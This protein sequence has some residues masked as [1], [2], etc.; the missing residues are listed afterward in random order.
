MLWVSGK[1]VAVKI[2]ECFS[3]MVEQIEEEY[4]VLRDLSGHANIPP[5]YGVYMWRGPNAA[6]KLWIV[7]EVGST[8]PLLSV[9]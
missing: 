4:H 3:G 1:E 9:Q 7:M 6:D 8:F 5:F 2:L